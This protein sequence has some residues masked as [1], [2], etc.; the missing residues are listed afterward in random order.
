MIG[1]S[2]RTIIPPERWSEEDEVLRQLRQGNRVDHFETVRRRKDGTDVHVSLTI[3]PIHSAAG[4]VV[5]ASKIARDITE[6]QLVEAERAR[7]LER[8]Q[9]ARAETE[10][11]GRL[12]D[13][14]LAVLSHEL[15]TPLNAVM[16]YAQLLSTGAVP[17]E[18]AAHAIQAIQRN[19]QAQA[20]LVESLLDLSR[21]LA[22]KLELNSEVLE[23]SSVVALAVDAVA[24]AALKKNISVRVIGTNDVRV[25]G[26][27]P[28]LQQVFWNL[29]SNSIKFTPAGGNVTVDIGSTDSE[30][31]IRVTDNGR[32]IPGSLLPFVFDRFKQ[33][34]AESSR[35][36]TGLGLG[37]ALVRELV[38]AHT[39][40]VI[41]E[42]AGE[43]LGS[44]FTV[45]IPLLLPRE[46]RSSDT[47]PTMRQEPA[48]LHQTRPMILVVDDEVDARH[49]LALM[50]ETRGARVQHLG[51][52]SE[53]FDSMLRQRP[54]VLLADLGLSGE[55]GYSLIRRWRTHEGAMNGHVPAIAVTAYASAT[56]KA[57]ALAAG[58]DWHIAKP[59]DADELVRVIVAVQARVQRS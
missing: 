20:R 9:A 21:V 37:L 10:R 38:H 36:R 4:V 45:R 33:G 43:G 55:D 25:F 49:V 19:A 57:R 42:S 1:R 46:T 6:R 39:G 44:T 23:L 5:G 32:G 41:A 51:T 53:A 40:T 48:D 13:D 2:I 12:K 16:G 22:G 18:S 7:L 24:P 17:A 26:D 47:V 56:D 11:A 28:R 59:V 8:E 30:A 52:A 3:S 34:E 15:R 35:A 31:V 14:F 58:F 54:D 50:L 27:G 29:L